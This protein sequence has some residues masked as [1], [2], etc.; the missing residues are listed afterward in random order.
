MKTVN[1]TL[2]VLTALALPGVALSA[3]KPAWTYGEIGYARADSGD[4]TTDAYRINASLGF[5]EQFHARVEWMDGDLGN[6]SDCYGCSGYDDGEV[7]GYRLALG[8]HPSL[9]PNTD[10]VLEV[11]YFDYEAE[12]DD[13]YYQMD[14][15]GFALA[16]GLRHMLT[17]Q[18]ELNALAT[19]SEG[20]WDFHDSYYYSGD[21]KPD[22]SDISIQFGGRYLFNEN[23]S[24]GVSVVMD[25]PVFMSEDSMTFDLRWQF[26][27]PF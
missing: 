20:E 16:A 14:A 8:A 3:A 21:N 26:A 25:D 22:F 19:W 12:Y 4:E 9:G 17:E 11:H 27:D 23:L 13:G 24:A 5:L 15:D 7:D 6:P 10:G 2:C 18:V 1:K